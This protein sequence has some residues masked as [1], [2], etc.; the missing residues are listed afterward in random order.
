MPPS[1]NLGWAAMNVA[2]KFWRCAPKPTRVARSHP[3]LPQL[4]RRGDRVLGEVTVKEERDC[5]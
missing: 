5:L 4:L 2:P 1:Y 3:L